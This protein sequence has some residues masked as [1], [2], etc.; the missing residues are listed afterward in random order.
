MESDWNQVRVEFYD[1]HKMTFA[2][3]LETV[4]PVVESQGSGIFS[5]VWQQV[6]F[7]GKA[8]WCFSWA[9]Q[10]A[11]GGHTR[12]FGTDAGRASRT[13]HPWA[14]TLELR[15]WCLFNYPEL[16]CKAR[17]GHCDKSAEVE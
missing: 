15:K 4:E 10:E 2:L 17:C 5:F 9:Q 7:P 1:R 13:G 6:L 16:L 12:P 14:A 8:Q 11:R 3:F